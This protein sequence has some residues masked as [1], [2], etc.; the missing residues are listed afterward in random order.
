MFSEEAGFWGPV[1]H[2]TAVFSE[3]TFSRGASFVGATFTE[4]ADF[5]N[6]TF[7][8]DAYF[9]RA[10]FASGACFQR[11]IFGSVASLVNATMK[12]P[13]SFE[14]A[15]FSSEPPRF[16]GAKLHEGT[17]WRQVTWPA[18]PP[19]NASAGKFVDAYERLK[20]E[21]DRLKKHEDEL[22]FF[23]L[24]LRSRRRLAGAFSGFPMAI[25]GVLCDYGR[26]YIRPLLG[27]LVTIVVGAVLCLPHFGASKYPQAI[28]LS[29]A[30]TF[31][32]LGFRKDFIAPYR[33]R[34]KSSR[35]YRLWLA[36]RCSSCLAYRSATASE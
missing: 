24:E 35:R 22:D 5:R 31:G 33:A 20:L 9:G 27:L 18:R 11:A 16:F 19:D 7:S 25:Y 1:F 8:D 3:A 17:V 29:L 12:G 2:H 6:T 10:T 4:E 28:G 32:V 14:A 15:V 21:M 13:T 23:A 26:S 36:S 34:S 30:N